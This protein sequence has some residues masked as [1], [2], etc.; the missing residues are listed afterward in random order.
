LSA[1]NASSAAGKV[2]DS[3][4]RVNV[5]VRVRPAADTFGGTCK[6]CIRSIPA[7]RQVVHQGANS[8]GTRAFTYDGIFDEASTQEE[9]YAQL[10]R[11]VLH[12]VLCGIHGCILAYG[13][14]GSGKTFSLLETGSDGDTS[15]C[16]LVPRIIT[17]LFVNI[18]LDP[19]NTYEVTVAMF[20][21]YNEQ[22]DDL[23][24]PSSQNLKVRPDQQTKLGWYVEGLEWVTCSDPEGLMHCFDV[25]RKHLKY[26]ET[27]M[28]KH[29]SRSHAVMQ[30]KVTRRPRPLEGSMEDGST[31]FKRY[32]GK[33]TIVDLAGSERI[34]KSQPNGSNKDIRFKEATNINTSLLA[35]G[36]VVQAL[37]KQQSHVPFRD[38]NL[39]R[40]LEGSLGGFS[41]TSLL[42]CVAPEL[43]HSNETCSTLEFA[44][45]A[46][47]IVAKPVVFEE[48][49]SVDPNAL[50]NG[51]AEVYRIEALERI[52]AARRELQTSLDAS[53]QRELDAANTAM[54]A[55]TLANELANRLEGAVEEQAGT[56]SQLEAER[57][58][59][60]ELE[61]RVQLDAQEKA[62]T[63]ASFTRQLSELK[64]GH[65]AVIKDL[66][67]AHEAAIKDLKATHEAIIKDLK[68]GHEAAM[69]EQREKFEK[70]VK[71]QQAM[72][73]TLQSSTGHEKALL[74]ASAKTFNHTCDKLVAS[75]EAYDELLEK[76]AVTEQKLLAVNTDLFALRCKRKK[77]H[78][79]QAQG[80]DDLQREEA[81][82]LEDKST[83][84]FNYNQL[85]AQVAQVRSERIKR[86]GQWEVEQQVMIKMLADDLEGIVVDTIQELYVQAVRSVHEKVELRISGL[87][88]EL[89]RER[90]ATKTSSA[91][92]RKQLEEQEL[93]EAYM[94][95]DLQETTA[96]KSSMEKDI[97]GLKD[98]V[99]LLQADLNHIETMALNNG[100]FFYKRGRNGKLSKRL[101]RCVSNDVMQLEWAPIGTFPGRRDSQ[102]KQGFSL[103]PKPTVFTW[104]GDEVVLQGNG[105]TL[106]LKVNSPDQRTWVQA[107]EARMPGA[108][109]AKH[110]R[111]S[112]CKDLR[113][114]ETPR[115]LG[116]G[117][118]DDLGDDSDDEVPG[119]RTQMSN[120]VVYEQTDD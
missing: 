65:E 37:A 31:P 112:I 79:D 103:P 64:A 48:T 20:Q 90:H 16:G 111:K 67:A 50:A 105:R 56:H 119:L 14:T 9:V 116:R 42:V 95:R 23:L 75:Q 53:R 21:I 81:L 62:S 3:S 17:E 28:N 98:N 89:A 96:R 38:S 91:M 88:T 61:R 92:L 78:P 44:S 41:R 59:C 107:L 8:G 106:T 43:Y 82:L 47:A 33:L 63:Q 118:G 87:E 34:K 24:E 110:R 58:R 72:I 45:R 6:T 86:K 94:E 30:L 27:H 2:P 93:R 52:E 104:V 99:R 70:M 74:I 66:K 76:V 80:S 117:G 19:K 46:I 1:A 60:R 71:Q 10:G 35:I 108:T 51:L 22:V 29:S 101:V 109:P 40:V 97:L 102:F 13:Q 85:E 39:T 68:A 4:G 18:G 12:D 25:G 69:K 100:A 54:E 49:V 32:M 120:N 55:E 15:D 83:Q 11:P 26:A 57:R 73:T 115:R 36:N 5:Y 7:Q 113:T 84:E 77:S 114:G